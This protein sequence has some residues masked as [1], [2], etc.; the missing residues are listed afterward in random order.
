MDPLDPHHV[1]TTRGSTPAMRSRVAAACLASCSR[2]GRTPALGSMAFHA[3]VCRVGGR[4]HPTAAAAAE[5][6]LQQGAALAY[7]SATM[8][9]PRPPVGPQLGLDLLI[10]LPGDE[11]VVVV[12]NEDLPLLARQQAGSGLVV[13]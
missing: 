11:P 4:H 10:A 6:S 12:R 1:M 5:P 13:G 7:R 8:A 9:A 2:A 3:F